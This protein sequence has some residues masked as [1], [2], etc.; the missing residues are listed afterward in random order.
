[1][2]T[3]KVLTADITAINTF[4]KTYTLYFYRIAGVNLVKQARIIF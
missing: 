4:L 1:M 3:K 2:Q